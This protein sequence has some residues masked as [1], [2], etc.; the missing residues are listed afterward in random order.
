MREILVRE[1]GVRPEN[2]GLMHTVYLTFGRK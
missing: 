2:M 1:A